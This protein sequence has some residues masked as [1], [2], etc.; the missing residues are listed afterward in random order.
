MNNNSEAADLI[1][2][3]W[4]LISFIFL[5]FGGYCLLLLFFILLSIIAGI[6][7][8]KSLVFLKVSWIPVSMTYVLLSVLYIKTPTPSG[9]RLKEKDA[10]QL[11]A[12]IHEAVQLTNCKKISA[13]YLNGEL[14]ASVTERGRMF[15]PLCSKRILIIGIPLMMAVQI[16]EFRAILLHEMSHFSKKHTGFNNFLYRQHRRYVVILKSLQEHSTFS[17]IKKLLVWYIN[18]LSL[19]AFAYS[20]KNEYEADSN[21]AAIAGPLNLAMGLTRLSTA[22]YQ[23]Y[24]AW[25]MVWRHANHLELPNLNAY[26]LIGA[27]LKKALPLPLQEKL[28]RFELRIEK[29]NYDT[30]PPLGDRLKNLNVE[31]FLTTK[32]FALSAAEHYFADQ[33]SVILDRF[34]QKWTE[35]ALTQ[36]QNQYAEREKLAKDILLYE[37]AHNLGGEETRALAF[38]YLELHDDKNKARTVL[39][40]Y[41][42]ENP[43]DSH[44]LYCM[45]LLLSSEFE[46]ECLEKFKLAADLDREWAYASLNSTIKYLFKTGRRVE[47]DQYFQALEVESNRLRQ[48]DLE[49]RYI[50]HTDQFKAVDI[51]PDSARNIIL[52]LLRSLKDI[53]SVHVAEKITHHCYNEKVYVIAV[54][55]KWFKK[56]GQPLQEQVNAINMKN[57]SFHLIQLNRHNTKLGRSVLKVASKL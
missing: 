34:N 3:K 11:F 37:N 15:L 2:P 39:Q 23:F 22:K 25:N 55:T 42:D 7:V 33:Y 50:Y 54:K 5:G 24:E 10:P 36:W 26:Q 30:H 35:Q 48:A 47:S 28:I 57:I 13:V 27:E 53:K 38:A 6:A 56:I 32:A 1:I 46:D 49:R 12:L 17:P 29:D 20:R 4:K 44:T 40:K 9:I 43:E 51:F 45:G 8:F 41:L 14:D 19:Y 16:E 21:A 31:P 18:R 52:N